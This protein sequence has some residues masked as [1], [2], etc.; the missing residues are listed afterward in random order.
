MHHRSHMSVRWTTLAILLVAYALRLYRLDVQSFAF[1]EGWTSYA[2]RHS[3]SEMLHVLAPDNHPPL[4]YLLT[5]LFAELVGYGDL[6]VRYL[7]VLCG[8]ATVALLYTLG[9]RL[10]GSI[11]GLSA[12]FFA[13]CSPSFIYYG[14][15]ARMYSLLMAL[16]VLASYCLARIAHAPSSWHWR[17]AYVGAVAALLYTHYFGVLLVFAHEVAW[18]AW[19]IWTASRALSPGPAWLREARRWFVGHA[20]LFLLYLPWLPV[21]VQQ[22]RVAQGTWWRIPLA[23]EVIA[24]DVWRF[25][26]LGPRRPP[27]ISPFG[28][29]VGPVALALAAAVALGSRKRMGGW[30]FALVSWTLPVVAIVLI[31]SQFSLYTDRYSLVALPGLATLVGLGVAAC[32]DALQTR[33]RWVRPPTATARLLYKPSLL[34]RGFPPG[35]AL[36]G[37]DDRGRRHGGARRVRPADRPLLSRS[38][39]RACFPA[40]R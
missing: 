39:A 9:T 18:L 19:S 20:V 6:S 15:E 23:A 25:F 13:A 10:S 16:T 7:S 28:P 35:S 27:G 11:A 17:A 40:A 33:H 38:S 22:A 26:V 36:P 5:K 34:A 1:D 3:W 29:Q 31:G 30:A 24:R 2:I 4:Y 14:Q 12:A 21:A 8:A 32:W 37:R